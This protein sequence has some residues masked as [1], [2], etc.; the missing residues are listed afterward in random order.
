ME[1]YV[2]ALVAVVSLTVVCAADEDAAKA[3]QKKLEGT[4][5]LVSATN[6]GKETPE[7]IVKKIRVVMKD[8]K[9]TVYFGDD[10]VVK[11]VPFTID[12]TKNPKTVVDT[13]PDGKE[14]KGIYKLDGDTLTT[15]VAEVGK[16]RP[17]EFTSKSGSGHTLRV[18]KRVKP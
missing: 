12:P 2:V 9:H 18:F 16:D 5:Q 14:I 1:K 17:T 8:G 15:C 3:E 4:W 10:V 7:E 11:E 6:D 13:L